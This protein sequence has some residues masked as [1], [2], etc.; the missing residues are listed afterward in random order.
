MQMRGSPFREDPPLKVDSVRLTGFIG[1]VLRQEFS[2]AVMV[3]QWFTNAWNVTSG[4]ILNSV[5]MFILSM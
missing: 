2:L 5:L 1:F 4:A 3:Y